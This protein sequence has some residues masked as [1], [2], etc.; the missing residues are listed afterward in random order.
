MPVDLNQFHYHEQTIVGAYGCSYY[1]GV[2]ALNMLRD[3]QVKVKDM[4]SHKMKLEA[5]DEALG[6]VER[7][8]G[9]KILLSSIVQKTDRRKI[10]IW[11]QC[12]HLDRIYRDS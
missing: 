6:I 7:R 11:T 8:E 1:H 9:M 10:W 3:G 5:L 12:R 2:Q 4:I